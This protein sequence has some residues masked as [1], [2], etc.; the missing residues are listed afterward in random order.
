M[1]LPLKSFQLFEVE[2]FSFPI[3]T[4]PNQSL[5]PSPP[6]SFFLFLSKL[7][8]SVIGIHSNT[9]AQS[10]PFILLFILSMFIRFPFIFHLCSIQFHFIFNR[11]FILLPSIFFGCSF[12]F[13]ILSGNFHCFPWIFLSNPSPKTLSYFI[14]CL[15]SFLPCYVYLRSCGLH[16]F[17]I[18]FICHFIFFECSLFFLLVSFYF[19]LLFD[20]FYFLLNFFWFS[21]PPLPR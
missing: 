1:P 9:F 19:L 21:W 17:S 3:P 7:S 4:Q 16:S 13:Y 14:F 20:L 11:L 2:I 6:A 8:S 10:I 15:I 12:I 5:P 18:K